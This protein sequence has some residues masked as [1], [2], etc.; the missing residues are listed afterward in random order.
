MKTRRKRDNIL[1]AG[2]AHRELSTD[3]PG[4]VRTLE[5]RREEQFAT[6]SLPQMPL[7]IPTDKT[8]VQVRLCGTV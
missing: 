7:L 1:L 2:E 4:T 5:V 3:L 8:V 6:C